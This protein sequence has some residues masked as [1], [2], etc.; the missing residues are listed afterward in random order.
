MY[1]FINK[2]STINI[3]YAFACNKYIIKLTHTTLKLK[4]NF[5]DYLKT[6]KTLI[7]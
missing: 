2:Y 1:F 7:F 3:Y 5:M 6:I 4:Y